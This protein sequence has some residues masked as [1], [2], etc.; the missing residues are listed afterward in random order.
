MSDKSLPWFRFYSE[1]MSDRKMNHAARLCGLSRLEIVGAWA[2][3]LCAAS[4]SPVRGALYVTFQKRYMMD[5]VTDLLGCSNDQAESIM[6]AFVEMEMLEVSDGAYKVKNW[7]KRQYKSDNSTQRVRDYRSK[8]AEI[9]ECNNDETLHDRYSNVSVTPPETETDTDTDTE[10]SVV[11]GVARDAKTSE[12]FRAYEQEM[13]P[14]TPMIAD[15]IRDMQDTYPHELI[16]QAFKTA[17][18]ANKRSISYANGILRRWKEQG[19]QDKSGVRS[20]ALRRGG[21]DTS[22]LDAI[23]NGE[24]R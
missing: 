19:V 21:V 11:V 5:D 17:A 9:T 20:P 3:I 10:S 6:S 24:I 15:A 14:L 23:I 1:T 8:P 12:I 7:D 2:L 4:E 13:G 18:L 22:E 16:I